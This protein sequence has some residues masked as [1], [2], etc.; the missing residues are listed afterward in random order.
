MIEQWYLANIQ[1]LRQIWGLVEFDDSYFNWMRIKYFVLPSVYFQEYSDLLLVTPGLNIENF[2]DY[3]FYV[4]QNL[5]RRD[6]VAPP[7][8]HEN[9][10]CNNLYDQGYAR[11]SFH[12]TSFR[13]TT[14]VVS[15]DNFLELAKAVHLFL[16]QE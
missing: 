5:S 2:Q 3:H 14:D 15:G 13:A 4:D 16:G 11:L 9:N 7:F 12:L 8:V 10:G 6:G 1:I